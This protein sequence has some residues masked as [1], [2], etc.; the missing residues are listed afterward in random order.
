L[1]SLVEAAEVGSCFGPAAAM[2]IDRSLA[3]V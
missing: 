2:S 1:I 3:L